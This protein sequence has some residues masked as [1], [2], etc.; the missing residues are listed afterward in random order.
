M[1][2][3]CIYSIMNPVPTL[4]EEERK[5]E[6]VNRRRTDNTMTME[7]V[8]KYK[9][10]STKKYME[11]RRLS[12]TNLTNNEAEVRGISGTLL[13]ALRNLVIGHE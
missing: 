12:N 9:Q 1:A 6:V 13:V 11:N 2:N 8:Q 4:E 10:W 7:K 3:D 5:P